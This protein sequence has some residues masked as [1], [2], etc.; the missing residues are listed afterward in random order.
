[1]SSVET[2]WDPAYASRL[3]ERAIKTVELVLSDVQTLQDMF[4]DVAEEIA[5]DHELGIRIHE[6]DVLPQQED[7]VGRRIIFPKQAHWPSLISSQLPV[8]SDVPFTAPEIHHQ[9]ATHAISKGRLSQA[10]PRV[11]KRSRPSS[12]VAPDYTVPSGKMGSRVDKVDLKPFDDS[13][14]RRTS[15]GKP[16]HPGST[17]R[18]SAI[19]GSKQIPIER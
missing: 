4:P 1:M 12:S 9:T 13:K 10:S 8:M 7:E 6:L 14:L 18:E 17:Q 19:N 3:A 11:A 16:H 5:E 15:S 2:H